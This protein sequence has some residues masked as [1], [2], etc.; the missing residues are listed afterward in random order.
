[1][2]LPAQSQVEVQFQSSP[3][4]T[5]SPTSGFL[6]AVVTMTP[7]LELAAEML[8]A[9]GGQDT[10]ALA[11]L[12]HTLLHQSTQVRRSIAPSYINYRYILLSGSTA[13]QQL[14]IT[15]KSNSNEEIKIQ[16]LE[17]TVRSNKGK[18]ER[19]CRRGEKKL[20]KQV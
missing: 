11:Q 19:V 8:G 7:E 6:V 5:S 12:V 14:D 16:R 3:S 4:P 15:F 20:K 18:E 9:T 17:T 13:V 10:P 2:L 1:M